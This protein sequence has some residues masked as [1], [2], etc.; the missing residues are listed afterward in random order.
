MEILLIDSGTGSAQGM[1]IRFTF[2]LLSHPFVG[3]LVN[4][5][6]KRD[7]APL[8]R[9]GPHS[10]ELALGSPSGSS[11]DTGRAVYSWDVLCA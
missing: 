6:G 7:S 3:I 5:V 11:G 8:C 10:G 1:G 9:A 4:L 2:H